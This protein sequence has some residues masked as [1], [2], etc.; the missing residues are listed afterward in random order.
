[1]RVHAYLVNNSFF[2]DE[3]LLGFN[4][5]FKSYKELLFPLQ[6]NQA[7]PFLFLFLT[8]FVISKLGISEV[9]FRLVPFLSSLGSVVAFYF[10]SKKILERFW[11]RLL[12]LF[13][14]CVNF[15]LLFYTQAFKPYSSDVL[16]AILVLLTAFSVDIKKIKWQYSL[17]LGILSS[18][19]FCFS[20]TS[21]FVVAGVAITYLCFS[22]EIKKTAIFLIPNFI[23]LIWYFSI[24]LST[25]KNTEYLNEYW[26]NGFNV[27]SSEIYKINYD[28]FFSYYKYPIFFVFLLIVG[29]IWAYKSDRL[30]TSLL[31]SPVIVT[32]MSAV[33][34]IY[35]FERRL[36][37]FLL[38]IFLLILVIPLD[39]VKFDKKPLGILV[40]IVSSIFFI[41]YSINYF[42]SFISH[43]VSYL[44]QD[45]RPLLKT[46]KKEKKKEDILYVYYGS[47]PSFIYYNMIMD[48]PQENLYKGTMLEGD[49]N[50]TETV[51]DELIHIPA[52]NT[53]WFFFVKGNGQYEKD[54]QIYRDWLYKNRTIKQDIILK[55]A[56]LIE[57]CL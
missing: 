16:V 51:K 29:I 40:I 19:A 15:Q 13:L 17:L 41:N 49:K 48:L 55:S 30:K 21:I 47:N 12:A 10:L 26:V 3:I 7:A 38:P 37:L 2:V 32:F 31:I 52:H 8:K 44:R 22:K 1:M 25:I 45:V 42:T 24:N 50:P 36:I 57:V 11:A 39:K 35:P 56:R 6:Y 33:L 46:L 20:F 4:V 23:I 53:V 5:M 14:F 9:A 34:R 18:L 54:V 28:F 43:K 27:F